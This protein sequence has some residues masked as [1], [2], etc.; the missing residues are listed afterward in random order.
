MAWE[1]VKVK[2]QI[3]TVM[4]MRKNNLV[5]I[6]NILISDTIDINGNVIA[7]ESSKI[8]KQDNILKITLA[9]ARTT[10]EKSDD[11]PIKRRS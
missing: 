10:K 5:D 4:G 11:K 9:V 3:E 8:N 6:P 2:G 7:V 1:Q